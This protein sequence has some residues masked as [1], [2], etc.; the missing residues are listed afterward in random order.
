MHLDM[1]LVWCRNMC[2]Q[3]FGDMFGPVYIHVPRDV[4]RV[5]TVSIRVDLLIF[6]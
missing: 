4:P 5:S 2:Q 3:V 6:G 1:L